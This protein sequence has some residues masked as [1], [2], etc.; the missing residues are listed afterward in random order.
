MTG[1]TPNILNRM[2]ALKWSVN[3]MNDIYERLPS[4]WNIFVRTVVSGMVFA[5]GAIGM[6]SQTGI[7]VGEDGRLV[8]GADEL[9]NRIPDF[10]FCGYMGGNEPI[11]EI[12]VRVV[13]S[14]VDGDDTERIQSAIDFVSSLPADEK[15][16]RGAVLLP[17]G[18][19]MI[20]GGLEIS[21]SGVVLRGQGM[22]KDGSVL[23]AVGDDRRTLIRI[24]G[25]D[26][27]ANPVGRDY[28][29]SDQYV[30]VG[31]MGFRL[32][33]TQGL[34]VGDTVSIIRPSTT[35]WISQLGMTEFGGG[36]GNWRG[37]KPG[38]RNL[39]WDRVIT[40]VIGDKILIDAPITT[41]IEA[42]FG[43]G[44]VR[45]YSWPGRISHVGVENLRCE[46]AF[47]QDNLKDEAHSW[48]ALTLQNVENAWV[49]Q[50]STSHFAGSAVAIWEGCKWVTVQN[51][52]SLS[53]V[54]ENGGYRRHTFFTMGQL[55]LFM[56]CWAEQGR[57]DFS[58]GHCAAGP[59]AFV[60]CQ[61]SLPSHY[62][63][64][65]ESWASGTLYDN[66]SIETNALR[67]CNRG[68]KGQ[69]IGWTAANSVLWQCSAAVI[70]CENPPTA[71]NW[72]FGCW[73]EFEGNGI[74][75]DSNSL[76]NPI[77]LYRSQ[78]ADRLG[79]DA[80]E[81]IQ[82]MPFSTS[83][84]TNPTVKQ[85][86]ELTIASRK[87]AHQLT[88]YIAEAAKRNSI[89]ANAGD[90]KTLEEVSGGRH[91]KADSEI[92]KELS[93]INGWLT[94]DGRLLTGRRENVAWWRGNIR[95]DE[96]SS[97]GQGVTRFVP[98]RIGPGFTDDLDELT[99][100]MISGGQSILEYN[101]GL[102]YDRRRDDHQ[103]IRR[104]DSDVLP[105]FYE[106]PF[107]RS[108]RGTAWDG[109][110]KYDLTKY[111]SW[112]WKR[113]Q[114]F[115]DLCDRKGLIL[116]HQNYFQHN[117]L[118][119]GA[120]WADFPWRSANNI[121]ETG[122]P[123]PPFYAGN[124]R[125]FMDELFYDVNHPVRRKLHRSY[126]RKCLQTFAD[127]TNVIQL[128]C[129]EFTGPLEFIQFWLD[130]I[131]DWQRETG[132]RAVIGL[133][134]TKDVQDAILNDTERSNVV[135]LIDV[136][137]WWY[138]SDGEL[139]SPKGGQHLAP[140]QHAR[141]L[142]PSKSSF[143]QVYRAVREYRTRYPSKA[144]LYS[145]T[146]AFGWAVLM[147]GGSIPNIHSLSDETLLAEIPRMKPF[148][149]PSVT[150]DQ[151]V[152]AE[153]GRSYLVYAVSG[154]KIQLDLT[155][156]EGTFTAR[157]LDP[158]NGEVVLIDDSVTG[159]EKVEFTI[160]LRPCVLWVT[161][162]IQSDVLQQARRS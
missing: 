92:R 156:A 133:S 22:G 135:S 111:N 105:P 136:R 159:G 13:V 95:P 155:E 68:S 150:D 45:P 24:F 3:V 37:W 130:T 116:L 7:S 66:V 74:W 139:Y 123:E 104:M 21:T 8:Y 106:M 134:C 121:N 89:R 56:H 50:I 2:I 61:A 83:S 129:A 102:W 142:R 112:Y 127:N 47:D 138:E 65:I 63:G 109:L 33:S 64:P 100:A 62:S 67:L 161:L 82:L 34:K 79:D 146:D 59:N 12:P 28:E 107:A 94:C 125:I 11:P 86:A 72:A 131:K 30:P 117:I 44:L 41:A 17:K 101:Y 1:Q 51:C 46:S 23:M 87:P 43:G 145:A 25:T 162:D 103:R 77:S 96:A 75:H 153:S 126:I 120:H 114:E 20:S 99:D 91:Q 84:A 110:S 85:A 154:E 119:A 60:Q 18:R 128:T 26:N 48:M 16:I 97:F 70:D 124:K 9:G 5:V 152:L 6:T 14:S 98:G 39:S 115:A 137:Y 76:V 80:A 49:R 143:E 55:T 69:G 108:G 73:G 160:R 15:G 132:Y 4:W 122:F 81:H 157:W 31:A 149:L 78:L 29:I 40:S 54:S 71:R 140:R 141:Q 38:T 144:V 36:L 53:P 35:E 148:Y 93:L 118:E 151:Y 52:I 90:A 10:S 27:K 147:G 19:Y 88:R 32:T 42:R 158:R 57:H 58:V 113:L